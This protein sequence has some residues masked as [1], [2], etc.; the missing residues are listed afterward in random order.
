MASPSVSEFRVKRVRNFLICPIVAGHYKSLAPS[1]RNEAKTSSFSSWHQC[2]DKAIRLTENL[3]SETSS[4]APLGEI[5]DFSKLPESEIGI[6][7][8]H[9]KLQII[10]VF[11]QKN[12]EVASPTE[13]RLSPWKSIGVGKSG[14]FANLS[15]SNY[16]WNWVPGALREVPFRLN[17]LERDLESRPTGMIARS[18]SL[19]AE[20]RD[21]PVRT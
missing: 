1:V 7:D 10:A 5:T 13:G 20:A 8:S 17:Y 21:F 16:G 3:Q 18:V 19:L 15:C 12:L 11:S 9:H 2:W 14:Y 6:V 4:P